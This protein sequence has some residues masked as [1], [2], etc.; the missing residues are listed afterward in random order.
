[1]KISVSAVEPGIFTRVKRVLA[2]RTL[3]R[4]LVLKD[5]KVRSRGS[6]LGIA[7][8]LMNP[9][10][11]LL[12]YFVIFRHVF[13]VQIENYFAFFLVGF[14]LWVFFSRAITAATTC[15]VE[16]EGLVK[17]AVFPLEVLPF[18]AV[19]H[20]FVHHLVA[21]AV[22]VL[23]MGFVG[24]IPF[25]WSLIVAV[26]LIASF[27]VFT[28][29]LALWLST[30]GVFF[31]DARDILEVGLPILFWMTPIVYS[32]DMA[33]PFLRPFVLANPLTS[34]IGGLRSVLL[35]GRLPTPGDAAAIAAWV[36]VTLVS[37]FWIFSRYAPTFSEE[38]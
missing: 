2:Y 25:T 15:L 7:W 12:I 5:L 11:S 28:L 16:N 22:A 34:F 23:F 8:T 21:L 18:A 14:V 6:Y 1:M 38:I 10:I 33:P 4:Y 36:L 32:L 17:R 26:P 31:L 3:V 29:A 13:R 27:A 37:G 24:G 30:I 9:L 35:D 20:Q 19:L